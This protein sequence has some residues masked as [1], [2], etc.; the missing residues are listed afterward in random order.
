MISQKVPQTVTPAKAG[1]QKCL[2]GL[3][4]RLRGHDIKGRFSTIY[5]IVKFDFFEPY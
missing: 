5:E 3:D 4:A 1:V 2:K